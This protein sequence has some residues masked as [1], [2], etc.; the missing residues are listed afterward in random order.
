MKASPLRRILRQGWGGSGDEHVGVEP[1]FDRRLQ[2]GIAARL[3]IAFAAV[4]ALVMAVNLIVEN[5]VLVERT[6]LVTRVVPLPAVAARPPLEPKAVSVAAPPRTVTSEAFLQALGRFDDTVLERVAG[7]TDRTETQYKRALQDLNR[8]AL[9]FMATAA[10]ISGRSF[11]KLGAALK[12]HEHEGELLVLASDERHDMLVKYTT[13]F[14]GLNARDKAALDHSWKMFGRVLA[15]QSLLQLSADLDTLRR[16]TAAVSSER[17]DALEVTALLQAEQAVQK[18]LVDNQAS[19]RS[20]EGGP[21]YEAMVA[22]FSGLV[23][24]R[25]AIVQAKDQMR[26]QAAKFSDEA[27]HLGRTVPGTVQS[28]N[29]PERSATHEVAVTI[30]ESAPAVTATPAAGDAA[31]VQAAAPVVAAP[32]APVVETH[33][34]VRDAPH[35]RSRRAQIAWIS[36]ASLI[37]LVYILASTVLSIVRPVRRLLRATAAL[38]G[39][40]PNARV[41]R[42]GIKELDTVAVA[43]NRMAEDLAAARAIAQDYQQSLER[44]V[45]QRTLALQE[46]AE[47]DPLTGL[48]NR[49]EW[50]SLL[51]AALERARDADALVGVFFLDIDN[52]KFINDSAGHAFGDRVLVSLAERLR[53]ITEA[54]GF[55]ARLGGDEF[56]VVFYGAASAEDIRSAGMS[57]VQAFQQPLAVDGR[58]VIV[59]VSVGASMYPVHERDAAALLKAADVAL[60][61]AKELGRGQLSMFTPD[62]LEAAA[63]KF[64]TEQG[65]R[66]AIER[67]EFELMFQPEVSAETLETSL[68]EALIR[69]RMPD[70][71]LVSPGHFLAIAEES[72]LSLDIGDWVLRSAIEAAAHWHHGAWPEVRVAINVS[73]RQFMDAGFI[74][75]LQ[76]LLQSHRLPPR[77]I[78]IELTESVLQTGSSTI[79][80]LRRLR[81]HGVAVA[82]DDFGSGYSSLASLEQLPLTRIK[83]D[84]G[85]IESID[86]GPRSAAIVHAVITLCHGLGLEVTAEGIER[87]EQ[88]EMLRKY[89]GMCMQGF[90]LARP[91]SRDQLMP[92]IALVARRCQDLLLRAPDQPALSIVVEIPKP[93]IRMLSETG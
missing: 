6:T 83:L 7:N 79:D 25:T 14:E 46:L 76:S 73:P 91:T 45:A 24:L 87:P 85:L 57:I 39:G 40:D 88:F 22:D 62:L 35:D 60:F 1:V 10:S 31:G 53:L 61:R 66:R 89:R 64:S 71:R 52:F 8:V 49:R 42:G 86:K 17:T 23:A 43:F 67:G 81:A 20:A 30:A 54:F 75:R 41:Q 28:P 9:D 34:V 37:L 80:A 93:S 92:E 33:S 16:H 65:L 78:E 82:L 55:C 44:T 51:N 2:L 90:L 27:A 38:A 21:W 4:G 19:L 70:G 13:L 84:R 56:T 63:V 58:E 11:S 26:G 59:S 68:V 32:T 36:A 69:W 72:G 18:R 5:G 29:A 15:R 74:D 77:C 50:F 47:N 48:P 12:S 3:G